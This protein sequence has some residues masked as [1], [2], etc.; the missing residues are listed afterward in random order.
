M[1]MRKIMALTNYWWLLTWLFT[2]GLMI[3]YLAPR[4]REIVLG[5]EEVRW[6]KGAAIGL[7]IP[8]IIWAGFRTNDFGDSLLSSKLQKN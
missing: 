4:K 1:E 3:N 8:Y 6:S 2:G 7:M 5:K